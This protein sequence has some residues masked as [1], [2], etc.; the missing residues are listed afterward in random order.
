LV[1]AKSNPRK[2]KRAPLNTITLRKFVP[3]A[4]N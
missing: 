2:L 4:S 1:L 3:T